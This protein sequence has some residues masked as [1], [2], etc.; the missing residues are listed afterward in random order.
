M[1]MYLSVLLVLSFFPGLLCA[2]VIDFEDLTPGQNI[3]G[4]N[5][6]GLYWEEGNAGYIGNQ[7]YWSFPSRGSAYPHSGTHSLIN[8]WGCTLIGF[9]FPEPVNVMGAYFAAQGLE[10]WTTAIRAHGYLDGVQI[11]TTDWFNDIDEF[12][13]WFAMNLFNV[14]R[15]VIESVPRDDGIGWYGMDD[16]TFVIPEPAT[17]SLVAAGMA[18][19]KRRSCF[20]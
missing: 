5:Y 16:L 19:L 3:S 8:A 13:D 1:K 7:G 20:R 9:Q 2:V 12:P 11:S 4:T 15:V 10:P 6:A 14:D 18:L 17:L